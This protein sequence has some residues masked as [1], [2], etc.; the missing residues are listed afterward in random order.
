MA[1]PWSQL[2]LT[3]AVGLNIGFDI[4]NDDDDAGGGRTAQAVWFGTV[5]DY[6]STAG[7]GTLVLGSGTGGAAAGAT[8]LAG[9]GR[10]PGADS[11]GIS[12]RLVTNPVGD[13]PSPGLGTGDTGGFAVRT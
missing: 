2:G 8:G 4:A 9:G 6:Q 11:G 7:F 13:G 12:L 3:P 10:S 1:I 5:N